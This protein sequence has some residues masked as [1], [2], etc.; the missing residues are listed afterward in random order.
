MILLLLKSTADSTN[1]ATTDFNFQDVTFNPR[2]GTSGQTKVEGIESSVLCHSS[3]GV[4]VT[5]SSP[6]TRQITNTNV[7]AVNVTITF[8]QLQ[9]A[10]DQWRFIRFF[11]SS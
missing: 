5:Q 11:C 2:F 10:T 4:T 8:P 6:V 9:R 1:P 7:D 3:V